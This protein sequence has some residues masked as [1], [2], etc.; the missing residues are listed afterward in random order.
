[1]LIAAT[2]FLPFHKGRQKAD[3]GNLR[4]DEDRPIDELPL[5]FKWIRV[6]IKIDQHDVVTRFHG[7]GE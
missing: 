2:G 7:D 5:G 4:M 1:M 3:W 6:V